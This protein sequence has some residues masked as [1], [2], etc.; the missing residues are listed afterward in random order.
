MGF[1]VKHIYPTRW[2]ERH[3][4]IIFVVETLPAIH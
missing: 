1:K 4:A 2:V 3:D